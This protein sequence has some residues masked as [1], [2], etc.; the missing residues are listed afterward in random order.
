MYYINKIIVVEGKEDASYLSSFVKA[1][2]VLTN[3]YDIPKEELDYLNEASKHKDILVLV[4]PDEAGRNIENRLK[5]KLNNATYL[6]INIKECNRGKKNGIAECSKEEII[7][8]LQPHFSEE[9]LEKSDDLM[10]NLSKI[11]FADK[12]LREY[13]SKKFHLGKCTYKKLF[14]RLQTLEISPNIL[15]EALAHYGNK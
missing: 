15:I 8:V 1:E 6:N 3:G 11:D 10:A 2:Y 7:N 4:D 13:L 5:E 14:I 12:N 9:L